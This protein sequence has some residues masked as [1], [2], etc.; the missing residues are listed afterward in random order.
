MTPLLFISLVVSANAAA[1]YSD[2]FARNFMFPLS[3]AAYS[4]RPQQ[5]IERLFP[6]STLQRLVTVQ[7]DAFRKDTCSGFTAVLHPQKA[8]VLSFRYPLRASQYIH[9]SIGGRAGGTARFLQLLQEVNKTIFLNLSSWLFGGR[10]SRYFSDAFSK[11]WS[12]GMNV[13]FH[14]LRS[15]HPDYEIWVT[16]H[17]LGGSVASLAA[18]FLIGSHIANSSEIKLVT[19][20]QPRTG[21]VKYSATHDAQMEYSFRVTHWRDIVPHIPFGPL[22]GYFHH[23]QE[24]ILGKNKRKGEGKECSDGLWFTSSIHEHTHY[25]GKKVSEYGRAGCVE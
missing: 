10:I 11:I 17:S 16:G 19:F 20:G 13:D 21:D 15:R 9:I 18:S 12:A 14:T 7:C 8:I 25:F 1:Q 4:D 2:S 24:V 3:A 23:R 22:G 5:C 6:N